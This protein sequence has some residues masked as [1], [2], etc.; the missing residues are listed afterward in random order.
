MLRA[1]PAGLAPGLAPGLNSAPWAATP[2]DAALN[3]SALV[4]LLAQLALA[5]RPAAAPSLVEGL[6]RWLG[7]REA[8]SVSTALQAAPG[9]V[10]TPTG[11][12]ALPQAAPAA[13]LARGSATGADAAARSLQDE[14]RCVGEALARHIEDAVRAEPEDGSVSSSSHT[15]GP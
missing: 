5:D 2:A 11:T 13:V 1:P 3:G 4:G 15:R 9:R 10:G 7:W 14:V 8:I 6:G 12:I